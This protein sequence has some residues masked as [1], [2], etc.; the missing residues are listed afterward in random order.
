MRPTELRLGR[1]LRRD[2]SRSEFDL[3]YDQAFEAV[4]DRCAH[5]PRDNQSGTWLNDDMSDAYIA[6]HRAGHAHSAE[7]W[8]EGQLVGG[9]YGVTLGGVFFGE[10]M[11]S[12]VPNA[13]KVVF[14]SLL[15]RL[16]QSGYRLVDCQVYTEYLAR[17]GAHEWSRDAFLESLKSD[18]VV[19]PSPRWPESFGDA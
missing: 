11:F 16:A 18:L 17:F 1:S 10:S 9:L 14:A 7:A 12:L 13:S 4:I 15:P 6:L 3:T 19:Q 2:I 8:L 5:V